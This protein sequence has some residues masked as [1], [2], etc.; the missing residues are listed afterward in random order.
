MEVIE[1]RRIKEDCNPFVGV[2]ENPSFDILVSQEGKVHELIL[3]LKGEFPYH[4][5]KEFNLFE[6]EA[7]RDYEILRDYLLGY[8]GLKLR[9]RLSLSFDEFEKFI[10]QLYV[11]LV[12]NHSFFGA[13]RKR[14]LI[15]LEYV[16]YYFRK[17][18]L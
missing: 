15:L 6:E 18:G 5:K 11:V 7:Y 16:K 14:L 4:I 1:F 3:Q 8:E 13:F 17:L 12:R 9:E 10:F 2:L